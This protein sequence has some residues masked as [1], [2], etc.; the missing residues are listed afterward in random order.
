MKR[1]ILDTNFLLIPG[2]F[3]VD[4][5]EEIKRCM[6]EPYQLFIVEGTIKELEHII[7][8]VKNRDK[9]ATKVATLLLKTKDIKTIQG[10]GSVDEHLIELSNEPDVIVATQDIELKRRLKSPKL[11]LRQR[12]Y[13]KLVK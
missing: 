6:D 13:I 1:I 4:I 3:K 12:K 10:A 8:K 5:F 2:Q 7:E 9:I 11:I